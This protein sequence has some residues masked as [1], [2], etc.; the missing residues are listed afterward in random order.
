MLIASL[1]RGVCPP[2]ATAGT[3]HER[4]GGMS[5]REAEMPIC[6]Q[7]IET[8]EATGTS[9]AIPPSLASNFYRGSR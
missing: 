6:P 9:V 7:D 8:G 1:Q 5:M 2:F 4:Q 3:R